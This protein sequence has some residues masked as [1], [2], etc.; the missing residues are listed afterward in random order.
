VLLEKRRLAAVSTGHSAAAIRTF[1]SNPV[2]VQFARWAVEIFS[3]AEDELGGDC[4]FQRIGYLTLLSQ[5]RIQVGKRVVELERAH[6]I[7]VEEL[8][9]D[10]IAARQPMVNLDGIA[11][12]IL[13]LDSRFAD[14]KKT[15]RQLVESA[16]AWNLSVHE[17][18]GA[19]SITLKQG[20]VSAVETEAGTIETPVVVNA[21][22]GWGR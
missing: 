18:V 2:T 20:R 10:D 8:T 3:H 7:R 6:G 9:P 5:D 22:G 21:A 16:K 17:N 13:E 12:G 19:T 15:T 14:P 11:Y 4:G 1:Y